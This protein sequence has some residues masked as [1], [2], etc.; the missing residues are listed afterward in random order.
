MA[1]G[2][3]EQC[4]P[5]LPRSRW[6][7]PEGT[8]RPNGDIMLTRATWDMLG[9]PEHALVYY[10]RRA[11][12]IGV[13]PIR[14]KI[15]DTFPVTPHGKHG[16]RIIRAASLVEQFPIRLAHPIRFH[17]A[18]IDRDGILNLDLST[19]PRAGTPRSRTQ[20]PALGQGQV[21]PAIIDL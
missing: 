10:S 14:A 20:K 9:Q 16:G 6:N 5:G 13:K 19:A 21:R 17:S 3:W 4:N 12:T 8:M 1:I 18:T 7:R 15:R 2:D 11:E